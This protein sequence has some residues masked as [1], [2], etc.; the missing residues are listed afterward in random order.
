MLLKHIQFTGAACILIAATFIITLCV[1]GR[2]KAQESDYLTEYRLFMQAHE[3]GDLSVAAVHGL[4]AWTKAEAELGDHR[5]TAILA[6]NYGKLVIFDATRNPLSALERAYELFDAGLA[7]LPGEELTAYRAYARFVDAGQRRRPS[8]ILRKALANYDGVSA[9]NPDYAQMWLHLATAD[10]KAERY[11][12]AR[13]SSAKAEEKLK[14]IT[15]QDSK[16]IAQAILFGGVAWVAPYPRTANDIINARR[17]FIRASQLFEPQQ[18]ISNFDPI[19]AAIMAWDY[20]AASALSSLPLSAEAHQR[21]SETPAKL[22][23]HMPPLIAG[24]PTNRSERCE[25]DWDRKPPRYPSKA[26]RRGYIGAAII[27]FHVSPDGAVLEPR[28]L[29]EVPQD[30]FGAHVIKSM[31]NW[32]AVKMPQAPDCLRNHITTVSFTINN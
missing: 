1:D 15:P 11:K 8:N 12:N 7:D 21:H 20:A 25:F 2:A 3:K 31:E 6:Y 17:A 19:F 14:A 9:S 23:G 29:A 32:Q 30:T 28:V 5:L 18:D 10:L 26:L 16:N 13:E 27:G 4:N 24:R 22:E